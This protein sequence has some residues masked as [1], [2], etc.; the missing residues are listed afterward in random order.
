MSEES[1][2]NVYDNS[3]YEKIPKNDLNNAK[4]IFKN[5]LVKQGFSFDKPV[6]NTFNTDN[7]TICGK[8]EN[9][10]H[11]FEQNFEC[12]NSKFLDEFSFKSSL[13][14]TPIKVSCCRF[15][16]DVDFSKCRFQNGIIVENSIF[17]GN[18]KFDD[19]LLYGSVKFNGTKFLGGVSFKNAKFIDSEG[20]NNSKVDFIGCKFD[21]IIDFNNTTFNRLV[22][23]Y[24]SEFKTKIDFYRTDFFGVVVLSGSIFHQNTLFTYSTFKDLVIFRQAKFNEGLDLSLANFYTNSDVNIFGLRLKNFKSNDDVRKDDDTFK[25]EKLREKYFYNIPYSNKRETFRLLKNY[26]TVQ[27]NKIQSL[28]FHQ[29]EMKSF[30]EEIAFFRTLKWHGNK[31]IINSFNKYSNYYGSSWFQGTLFTLFCG[32]LFFS[33]GL[34]QITP[35]NDFSYSYFFKFLNPTHSPDLM[36]EFNPTFSY[37]IWDYLGRIFIGYGIYQTIAAFRGYTKK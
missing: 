28:D 30:S 20:G 31:W 15:L 6:V 14:M 11:I 25:D 7:A 4:L 9:K 18:V 26:S 10:K 21:G 29:L 36:D 2:I 17:F 5:V 22:D 34:S 12:N 1:K 8:I 19:S 24:N 32:V 3:E 33:L 16:N 37:Y 13:I 27:N 35:T 23:F